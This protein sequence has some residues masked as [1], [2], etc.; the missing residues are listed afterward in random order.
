MSENDEHKTSVHGDTQEDV[1]SEEY[2]GGVKSKLNDE[3][4]KLKRELRESNATCSADS[5]NED[6]SESGKENEEKSRQSDNDEPVNPEN[7]RGDKEANFHEHFP[8]QRISEGKEFE[9]NETADASQY[10][11]LRMA[12][13]KERLLPAD[14]NQL[15]GDTADDGSAFRTSVL[16]MNNFRIQREH[17]NIV[18]LTKSLRV[19]DFTDSIRTDLRYLEH[20]K[21]HDEM[22]LSLY[23]DAKRDLREQIKLNA[24]HKE[25][26]RRLSSRVADGTLISLCSPMWEMIRREWDDFHARDS[27]APRMGSGEQGIT[28]N[29]GERSWCTLLRKV[30]AIG[31]FTFAG[32]LGKHIFASNATVS[33]IKSLELGLRP[34]VL[35]FSFMKD[36]V[37]SLELFCRPMSQ[38]NILNQAYTDV[39]DDKE[40]FDDFDA[41]CAELD[42]NETGYFITSAWVLHVCR[43]NRLP[44]LMTTSKLPCFGSTPSCSLDLVPTLLKSFVQDF[45][46]NVDVISNPALKVDIEKC[47]EPTD[48]P[49]AVLKRK[50]D[51]LDSLKSIFQKFSIKMGT[52]IDATNAKAKMSG[53]PWLQILHALHIDTFGNYNYKDMD[54]I[55]ALIWKQPLISESE[56]L[57]GCEPLCSFQAVYLSQPEGRQNDG[58]LPIQCLEPLLIIHFGKEPSELRKREVA[59]IV[60]GSNWFT[61]FQF[62]MALFYHHS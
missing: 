60:K 17:E 3:I 34:I 58:M 33:S 19:V 9:L 39:F 62:F 42:P 47:F 38:L 29:F 53:A 16:D 15:Q 11:Y 18:D 41:L 6:A 10:S 14:S 49:I 8:P 5:S 56:F 51:L 21:N 46:P 4:E 59:L 37:P 12:A 25:E 13:I 57:R 55:R 48:D 43:W 23:L 20:R 61:V 26:L 35:F 31:P 7:K 54:N 45:S 30:F 1:D 44:Y 27:L 40:C 32:Y 36:I 28:H 52:M 22:T 24:Q 2:F 50:N